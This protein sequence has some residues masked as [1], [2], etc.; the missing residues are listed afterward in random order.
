[1]TTSLVDAIF[2]FSLDLKKDSWGAEANHE[3]TFSIRID[4]IFSNG[5]KNPILEGLQ[6][7]RLPQAA[8]GVTFSLS[9]SAVA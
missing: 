2:L 3:V 9:Q 7:P 8:G 6:P 5:R 4:I 1:M